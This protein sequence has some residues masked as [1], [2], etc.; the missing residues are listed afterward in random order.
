MLQII[1]EDNHLIAV[2]KPNGILV[3]GDETGDKSL[4]TMVKEYIKHRYNKPG[5]VYLATLHRIDRPTSGVVI[6]GRT[7]KAASR[8][9]EL[10]KKKQ[11][12]K[13]YLALTRNRPN[14]LEG[15][16][17]HFL[18]KNHET[19]IVKLFNK[20]KRGSKEAILDYQFV[21]HI[22]SINLTK[23][24]LETGRPHQIRVQL[25]KIKCPIIGDLKYNST[26]I[27]DNYSIGLHCREM[28][29]IHPVKKEPVI[30]KADL[31][32]N[33]IWRKFEPL[34]EQEGM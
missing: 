6:F 16:L 24:K 5:D 13:T 7:S 19:N 31:P 30:I 2:N 10:M 9:T 21:G 11:I 8:M 33:V 22:D 17:R 3:H 23:V 15:K 34:V 32:D 4:D 28:S 18:L 1:Y 29:F 27:L 12:S 25:S 14:P 20:E 26:M